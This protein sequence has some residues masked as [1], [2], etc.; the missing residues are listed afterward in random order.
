MRFTSYATASA[1]AALA[2]AQTFTDC[3]PME[4][5]CPNNPAMPQTWET[6]FTAGKDAIKGWKQ[7]A[8]SLTYSAEGA[9][10]SVAKKGD[11]PTI[12]SEAYLHFGY[13]EVKMKA[14]PGQGIIS[15]IVLQSDDLD[16]VDW[17][18]IGGV[19]SK[20]QMNY[21]GKG[22]TTTY[23]RMIEADVS[24]TQNEFH[25]YALNWTS[26]SLTWII[27][28]K[29]MRTLNYADANGGKN[30]PQTPCNVRLGNWPGGDSEN[31]GTR[32]WAGGEVD[33]S[34]APF[35][36]TV[37]NI[38][39]INYSP[40]TEY[41]W[42]DKSGSFESIE[43][44]G[45]GNKDGA[46]QNN[47][48]LESS[49]S[50]TGSGIPL[51]SGFA[52]P[53]A[54]GSVGSGNSG[55]NNSST[56]CTEGQQQATPAPA[57]GGNSDFNYP[58]PTGSAGTGDET[59]C[60]C[61]VATVTVTGTPPSG[62]APPATE[63][64]SAPASSPVEGGTATPPTSTAIV[65]SGLPN[66]PPATLTSVV[67]PPPYATTGL[68]MDTLPAPSVP[69]TLPSAPSTPSGVLPPSSGNATVPSPSAPA[70]FTGA[71]S[72]N[73]A[74]VAAMAVVGCALLFAL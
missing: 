24:S 5:A 36:M 48:V 25:T 37:A 46:P 70:E 16:E 53:S 34:K 63:T 23:D 32:Q 14:A 13:I 3:N 68:I 12:G 31:E 43:V 7:T 18:W 47:A 65:S 8:G 15:S 22:N 74:G 67:S 61:G 4:K 19:D 49:A 55:S 6:D 27:D 10:F 38:K 21:F 20:T 66:Q 71:A 28:N 69:A 72:A 54:T 44:V 11:A 62:D 59:P 52:A 60:S 73:K 2:S 17:E 51:E 45:A 41:H 40:G 1:L 35:K 64:P 29:P 50:A 33:Y 42:K 57:S 58:V 39:V 26:E 56:T 30:F 9:E